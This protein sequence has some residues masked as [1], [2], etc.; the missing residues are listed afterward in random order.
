M[1]GRCLLNHYKTF[2]K[3]IS[4]FNQIRFNAVSCQ[5]PKVLF[6]GTDNFSLPSLQKLHQNNVDIG[7]VTSF[8]NPANCVRKYCEHE[9]LALYQWP[10][11]PKLCASYELGVVVSFGHLIPVHI[12]NAFACGIIN[13]HASLLPRWRGAAP[14]IYAIMN[15]DRKTG[16]SIMNIQ[17]HHFDIGDILAQREMAIGSDIHMPELHSSLAQLGAELLLDTVNNV[18]ERIAKATP[19]DGALATYAPKITSRI[20][21]I[22]W[23]E[24]NSM[25]IYAR[26]RALYGFKCLTT[27]FLDKQVQLLTVRK[28][29]SQAQLNLPRFLL[30]SHFVFHRGLKSL[31]I[32]CAQGTAIEV[33]QMRIEG[34]KPMSALDFNNGFLK[35]AVSRQFKQ[36]T[37]A[38]YC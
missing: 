29:K 12:I 1:N 27:S 30:P 20:T 3:K 10:I 11:T 26:Y 34:K 38:A 25:E 22:E 13:V 7:V 14:I 31:I 23:A 15:G 21:E 2:Q 8:K 17:P 36:N 28:P 24:Q 33:T 5:S 6:F 16:V 4:Q 35:Q 19:Q 37:N 9:N 32:G 18:R